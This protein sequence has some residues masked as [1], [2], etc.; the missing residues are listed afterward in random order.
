[1]KI[2]TLRMP[3]AL[4]KQIRRQ[5]LD[6]NASMNTYILQALETKTETEITSK[7]YICPMCYEKREK[8]ND[9]R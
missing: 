2:T 9:R 4:H 5:A 6:E 1:M 7:G 3:D 8:K